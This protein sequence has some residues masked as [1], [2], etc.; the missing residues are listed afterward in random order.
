MAIT[1]TVNWDKC[2]GAGTC[3]RVAPEI[4]DIKGG[5]AEVVLDEIPEAL[6]L[7]ATLAMLQCPTKAISIAGEGFSTPS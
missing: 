5:F 3:A 4:F 2:E 6:R 1:A 7:K